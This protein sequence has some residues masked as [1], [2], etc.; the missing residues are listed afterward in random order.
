MGACIEKSVMNK[1]LS[2][3]SCCNIREKGEILRP[4]PVESIKL[5]STAHCA[6][7]HGRA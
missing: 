1:T 3:F 7:A 2:Q 4:R 5:R 6:L